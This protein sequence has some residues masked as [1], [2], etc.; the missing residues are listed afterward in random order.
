[1]AA[2]GA[3]REFWDSSIEIKWWRNEYNAT[4]DEVAARERIHTGGRL[5]PLCRS[6]F[7][8]SLLCADYKTNQGALPQTRGGLFESFIRRALDDQAARDP[9][10][11][12]VAEVEAALA[13]LADAM[14]AA[15]V[16]VLGGARGAAMTADARLLDAGIAASLLTGD[17]AEI[18]FAHQLFQEYFAT[19][20]LLAAM[21]ADEA[22]N[23][24]ARA[25][26]FFMPDWWEAGV[27]RETTVILGEL[28]GAGAAGANR[29][30]RWLAPVTPDIALN[31]VLRNG[32]GL[33]LNDLDAA[34]RAALIAGARGRADEENPLGRAAA[35]RVLGLLGAD[36]RPGVALAPNHSPRGRGELVPDIAWCL[37]RAGKFL[38]GEEKQE[39]DL[40]YDYWISQY[41]VTN[42]QFA[43]FVHGDGYSNPDYWTKAGWA[44][45]ESRGWTQ[46]RSWDDP[47]WNIGNH[48]VVGVSWYE[49]Y[50]YTQWLDALLRRSGADVL[51]DHVIR[52]PTEQEWEK[53]A[54]GRDGR[55]YPWGDSW[56]GARCNHAVG[57]QTVGRTS[58][59][60]LYSAGDTDGRSP[61]EIA[62]LAGNVWEWCL[63]RYDERDNNIENDSVRVLRGGSW[64]LNYGDYFRAAFRD[65]F[66][67]NL[68]HFDG[69]FRLARSLV[70]KS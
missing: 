17:R 41:P 13:R 22:D 50:A 64:Y 12:P 15:K 40:P 18:R 60:G 67:P 10:Y 3:E 38:Y 20:A 37:V 45:K 30:A 25:A 1:M 9:G 69:G 2:A 48:P 55:V 54:R 19:R 42:A 52:L 23:S 24:S 34:T 29:V 39:A 53:A 49:A 33:T 44:E 57:G 31:V 58:A 35:Y 46:P 7:M 4:S 56:D 61:Y 70:L 51:G 21:E 43:P 26:A 28:A 16:T 62:D 66:D 36:E 8:A 11:P 5:I 59:V 32:A 65:R 63:T 27:W 6:P 68:R 47:K 14:Q